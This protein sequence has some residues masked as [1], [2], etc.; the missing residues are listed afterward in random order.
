MFPAI[1]P[2]LATFSPWMG[3]TGH[4]TDPL[5][6]KDLTMFRRM[7]LTLSCGLK[8]KGYWSCWKEDSKT[9]APRTKTHK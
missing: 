6:L 3:A 8:T 2:N 7:A 4:M 5:K 9:Y 1:R